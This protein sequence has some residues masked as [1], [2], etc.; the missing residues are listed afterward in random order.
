MALCLATG[1]SPIEIQALYLRLKDKIFTGERPYSSEK[2]EEFLKQEFGSDTKMSNLK[3]PRWG[4]APNQ[5]ISRL[6]KIGFWKKFWFKAHDHNS[7]CQSPT[8]GFSLLSKLL[9]PIRDPWR[10]RLLYSTTRRFTCLGSGKGHWSCSQVIYNFFNSR[11]DQKRDSRVQRKIILII[12]FF[13]SYFRLDAKY[14]DGMGAGVPFRRT[15]W[16]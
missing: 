12:I 1:K 7:D 15:T 3:R 11:H 5:F 9:I 8:G 2:M 13:P 14:I 6:M 16:E 10:R 4:R